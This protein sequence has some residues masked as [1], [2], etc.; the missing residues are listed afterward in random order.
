MAVILLLKHQQQVGLEE[1]GE[2]ILGS[3]IGGGG[4]GAGVNSAL[5]GNDVGHFVSNLIGSVVG[6]QQNTKHMQEQGQNRLQEED[7]G[8]Q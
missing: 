4:V 6:R 1:S 3:A 2:S 7:R 5:G 8:T